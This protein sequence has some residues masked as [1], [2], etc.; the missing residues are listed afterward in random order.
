MVVYTCTPNWTPA[1]REEVVD[2]LEETW[3]SRGAFEHEAHTISHDAD[4]IALDFVTW[5]RDDG[6]FCTGRIKVS[7]LLRPSNSSP[8]S[9]HLS[10]DG[11]TRRR[12]L[13]SSRCFARH[14]REASLRQSK[15]QESR[16]LRSFSFGLNSGTGRDR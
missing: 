12:L 9:T 15:H 6:A 10:F 8:H 7:L 4:G 13:H 2:R 3:L 11:G 14:S 5:R 16:P 1:S